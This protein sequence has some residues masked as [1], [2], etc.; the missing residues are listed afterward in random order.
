MTIGTALS[1]Y[2]GDDSYERALV[3]EGLC[4]LG[5]MTPL[6]GSSFFSSEKL[7]S[8]F[9]IPWVCSCAWKDISTGSG[10]EIVL[11]ES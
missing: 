2:K 3:T 5:K 11:K 9:S 7:G 4:D 1:K 6:L 10:P 8:V